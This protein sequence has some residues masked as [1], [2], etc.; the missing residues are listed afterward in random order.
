M[1]SNP[2]IA[3][4]IVTYNAKKWLN[5]C[6]SELY[7]QNNIELI[8]VDN[9]SSDETCELIEKNYPVVTLIKSKINLGFGQANNLGLK[10][11]IEKKY[12]YA[13]LQNQDASI[14]KSNLFKLANISA[15]NPSY[16][17]ISPI[18]FKNETEVENLFLSYLK[19]TEFKGLS[20]DSDKVCPTDF[21]NAALWLLPIKT[22]EEI[23]GFNPLFFHYGEDMDYVNRVKYFDY[24]IGFAEG[25]KA[26]HYRDYDI[27]KVR[28]ESSKKRHFGPWQPKYYSILS[29]INISD[30]IAFFRANILFLRSILK[31]ILSFNFNSVK[32][33]LKIYVEV[34]R[35]MPFIFFNNRKLIKK[36][37]PHFLY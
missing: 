16:G 19:N 37:G 3:V 25:V 1:N 32:W 11:A 28:E 14:S 22:V 31:H 20:E 35:K 4:I 24:N 12:D 9:A 8:V 5:I 33:D 7:D 30:F 34:V 10:I 26:Y 23:G 36:R 2:K 6:L 15:E 21:I 29:N 17:I 18:H 27:K 13:F